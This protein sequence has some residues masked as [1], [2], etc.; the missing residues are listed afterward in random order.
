MCFRAKIIVIGLRSSLVYD[1]S[2]LIGSWG[3]RSAQH[4]VGAVLTRK[5][6]YFQAITEAVT[7][8]LIGLRLNGVVG[9]G[10]LYDEV[11]RLSV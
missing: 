7:T 2:A 5:E 9:E 6:L 3:T 1:D 10:V 8:H 4:S 11:L